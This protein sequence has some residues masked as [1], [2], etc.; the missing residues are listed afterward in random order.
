MGQFMKTQGSVL[1]YLFLT[2]QDTAFFKVCFLYSNVS[3]LCGIQL[4]LMYRDSH[5]SLNNL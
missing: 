3:C 4:Y 5:E 1:P 2:F